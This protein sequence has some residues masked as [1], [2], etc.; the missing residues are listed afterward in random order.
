ME[1]AHHPRD[2]LG[3][4][5]GIHTEPR[6]LKARDGLHQ[7]LCGVP[8]VTP[9]NNIGVPT[10]DHLDHTVSGENGKRTVTPGADKEGA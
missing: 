2:R 6:K 8:K 4:G 5:R 9:M 10:S 7:T 3:L 1:E